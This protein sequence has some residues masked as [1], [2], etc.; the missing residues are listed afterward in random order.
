MM[1]FALTKSHELTYNREYLKIIGYS[2][3]N[4]SCDINDGK[5]TLGIII[6]SSWEDELFPGI[7]EN[8]VV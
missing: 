3:A 8:G 7:V 5:C 4:L 2:K 1:F 6:Y